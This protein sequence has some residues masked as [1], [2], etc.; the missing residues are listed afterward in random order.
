MFFSLLTLLL[1]GNISLQSNDVFFFE[2]DTLKIFDDNLELQ[3]SELISNPDK[4]LLDEMKFKIIKNKLY[5]LGRMS[6]EVYTIENNQIKRLDK[7]TDHRMTINANVFVHNDTL[8]KYGGYGYWSQRNFIIYYDSK[9]T[10]WEVYKKRGDFNPKGQYD[11]LSFKQNNEIIFFGGSVVNENDR[12]ETKNNNKVVE[13]DFNTNSF[14]ELGETNRPYNFKNLIGTSPEYILLADGKYILKIDALSNQVYRYNRP[15]V[16]WNYN[17]NKSTQ[18]KFVSG[19]FFIVSRNNLGAIEYLK[20][21]EEEMFKEPVDSFPL[22]IKKNDYTKAYLWGSLFLLPILIFLVIKNYVKTKQLILTPNGFIIKKILYPILPSEYEILKKLIE[23]KKLLTQEVLDVIQKN[24]LS[25][26]HNIRLK[27][28]FIKEL[29]IK[30]TTLF[31]ILEEPIL[32]NRDE[33][34]RRVKYLEIHPNSRRF[35]EQI[36]IN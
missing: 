15:S 26:A 29:N 19:H 27:E 22:Y 34:D 21:S 5:L 7:T 3:S 23:N 8:L 31:K 25:Y 11:G 4:I 17:S 9:S 14:E 24:N 35:F 2:G 36:I 30:L 6:G 18:N 1:L 10:E 28:Q 16:L 13:F 33:N 20:I 12:L 32:Q